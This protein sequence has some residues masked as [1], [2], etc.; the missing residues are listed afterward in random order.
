MGSRSSS[1][2]V[3]SSLPPSSMLAQHVTQHSKGPL[4]WTDYFGKTKQR[5]TDNSFETSGE[6][7]V[8]RE[9]F[10]SCSQEMGV[11]AEKN[12][13]LFLT[14]FGVWRWSTDLTSEG[15]TWAATMPSRSLSKSVWDHE[16]RDHGD[17]SRRSSANRKLTSWFFRNFRMFQGRSLCLK[18]R[19]KRWFVNEFILLYLPLGVVESSWNVMAHGDA[20]EGKWRGNWRME[21]VA[22]A[23]HTTSE[24]GVSRITTAVAHTSAASSRLNWRPC[25]FK[26]TRPFRRKTKS[27]FCACAIR[28][29]TQS[30]WIRLRC[31]SGYDNIT[32]YGGGGNAAL[33]TKEENT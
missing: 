8:F 15:H 14:C 12:V 5:N 1:L 16:L 32:R 21:W 22:S 18:R 26:W 30:T 9:G 10:C 4:T 24:R 17:I 25:R 33:S 23:L 6:N 29:Q 13:C 3:L 7:T 31:D 2:S 19:E 27:G 28:F 20:R 11:R